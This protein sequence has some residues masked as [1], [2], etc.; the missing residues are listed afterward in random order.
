MPFNNPVHKDRRRE[1]RNNPTLAEAHLWQFLRNRQVLDLKF[2]R[3]FG[4]GPFILDLYC[5]QINL[6]I[7]IDGNTHVHP[8]DTAYDKKRE[9][10]LSYRFGLKLMRFSNH[11]VLADPARVIQQITEAAEPLLTSPSKGEEVV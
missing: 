1:L 8:D 4:I 10:F 7:E 5:P 11:D 2:R 9:Q 3:Q 6:G